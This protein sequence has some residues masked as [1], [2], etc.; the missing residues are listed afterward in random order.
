MPNSV[1]PSPVP[2]PQISGTPAATPTGEP[3][4]PPVATDPPPLALSPVVSGLSSPINIT[5][6]PDGWLLVNERSG[7]IVAVYPEN[8]ETAVT[9]DISDRVLGEGERGLLGLAL[10]PAWRGE[11][12]RAFV[13]YTDRAGDT[14]LSEFSMTDFALPPRLDP[15]TERVLLRV[16]QPYANHNGGQLAF[17]P[18]GMLYLGLGD[19]GSGG[20]PHDNG[21]DPDTLLGTILRLDVSEPG[22]ARTPDDAPFAGGGGAPEVHLSGLRN[23][24]RFSFDRLTG[25]LWIADVGQNAYEEVNRL[26]PTADA[27]GNLGWNVMEASHCFADANCDTGAFIGPVSEYGRELGC[28]ITGGFVYRGDSIPDLRGWYLFGDYCGGTIFG[29]RSDVEELTPPR[30]LLETDAAISSFGE[31]AEGEL[32]LADL[33]GAIYR[34]VEAD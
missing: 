29:I 2:S 21:Q 30:V 27:G 7:R 25:D 9:L 22:V 8:G 26:D 1:S 33:R 20:D 15:A 28:S 16:D 13:H 18:D 6:T 32:Y 4:P 19:G 24:W 10:H 5:A 31:N 11:D 17:G 34:I 14:V 12:L 3:T 23:P